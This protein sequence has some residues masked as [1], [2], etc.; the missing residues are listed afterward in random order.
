MEVKTY[1]RE[2]IDFDLLEVETGTNT[3]RGG[4]AGHGGVTTF[5]IATDGEYALRVDQDGERKCQ[6]IQLT[7]AGDAA[8]RAFVRAL[9]VA[10]E[11]LEHQMALN[12]ELAGDVTIDTTLL[13]KAAQHKVALEETFREL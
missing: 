6:E 13:T 2:I 4:D 12:A 10:T 1:K 11:I 3:P 9:R 7:M 5:R 8:C